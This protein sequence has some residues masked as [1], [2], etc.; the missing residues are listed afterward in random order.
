MQLYFQKSLSGFHFCS[1]IT[2][3]LPKILLL[4]ELHQNHSMVPVNQ[5]SSL[6]WSVFCMMLLVY[7]YCSPLIILSTTFYRL[8]IFCTTGHYRLWRNPT[9]VAGNNWKMNTL[10]LETKF[11]QVKNFIWVKQESDFPPP[12]LLLPHVL[13]FV[14]LVNCHCLILLSKSQILVL[15]HFAAL[16]VVEAAVVS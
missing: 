10:A 13:L 16:S 12:I 6:T 9:L 15:F 8:H 4:L 3:N 2:G 1:M 5:C 7:S 14:V 11:L